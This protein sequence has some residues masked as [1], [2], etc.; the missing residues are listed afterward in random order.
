MV[1]N[2]QVTR[3]AKAFLVSKESSDLILPKR[4]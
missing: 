2:R 3:L 4:N 1:V